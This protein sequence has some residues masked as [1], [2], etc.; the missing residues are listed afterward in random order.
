M[1]S[2]VGGIGFIRG[3]QMIQ[4]IQMT[5]I[6]SY[7]HKNSPYDVVVD[8]GIGCAQ[9]AAEDCEVAKFARQG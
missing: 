8:R 2:P 4:M 1:P 5:Y 7:I 9:L 3:D 6:R